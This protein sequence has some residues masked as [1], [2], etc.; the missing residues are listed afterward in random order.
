MVEEANLMGKSQALINL[1]TESHVTIV[2][3]IF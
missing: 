3:P 2:Y 1:T